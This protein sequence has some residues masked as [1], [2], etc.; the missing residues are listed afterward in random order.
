MQGLNVMREQLEGA[1][2]LGIDVEWRPDTISSKSPASIVQVLG[3][4]SGD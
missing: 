1:P 4:S 2:F 3:L